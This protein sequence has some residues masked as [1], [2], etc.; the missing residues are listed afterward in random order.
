MKRKPKI[1]IVEDD[2]A[3]AYATARIVESIGCEAIVAPG[4]MAGFKIINENKI[5]LAIAD[6]K[7]LDREPHGLSFARVI[8]NPP[9]SVPVI[10][11]TAYPDLL[12]NEP[13]ISWPIFVK[14]IDL[15]AFKRAI[16]SSLSQEA[17]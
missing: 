8:N 1:L 4:A 7:L 11:I 12:K 15:P 17:R 10:L 3:S 9:S 13:N 5:D 14:P 6:I 16:Q 2:E